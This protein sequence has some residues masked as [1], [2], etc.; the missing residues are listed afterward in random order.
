MTPDM[1]PMTPV[2]PTT[3]PQGPV[4][5][6]P[7]SEELLTLFKKEI[8]RARNHRDN[9]ISE[10]RVEDNLTRYLPAAATA[11]GV[12]VGVD[13]RDVERKGAALFYDTPTVNVQP[14]P[15]GNPQAAVLQQELING[16]LSAQRMNG[17]ATAIKAIKDCLVAIQPAFTVLGY[18]PVTVDVPSD[19]PGLPPTTQVAHDAFF[20]A[21]TSNKA[22]L[23][24]VDFHDTDYQQSPWIGYDW[25]KPCQQAIRE[26]NLP[27]DWEPP[28]G[29][30]RAVTFTEE[31]DKQPSS[32]PMCSGTLLWYRA[33]Q[34]DP[35]VRHPELLRTLVLIDG[36]DQ[37]VQHKIAPWQIGPNGQ[38]LLT[39]ATM[40]GYPIR[41][42]ALRDAPDH[43][44]VPADSS[45][46]GPLTKEINAYL[47]QAKTKRESNRLILLVDAE[48]ID[49][50]A[51]DK[52]K[53]L[54]LP[55]SMELAIVPV[56][57]GALDGGL[58][59]VMQQVQTLDLGRETY[60][61]L[62]IF[63]QK[64][65]QIL[66]I[67]APQGG[68]QNKKER[69]ATEIAT[70]QRNADARFEQERQRVLEWWLGVVRFLS[71]LLVRYGERWAVDILGAPRAQQWM[72]F[73]DQGLLG[74]FTFEVSIDS[75]KYLDV[76]ADRRQFLQV[77]NF[78][79]KSPFVNQQTM[80]RKFCEKF[81]YDPAEWLVQPQPPKPDPPGLTVSAK[82]EDFVM[83]QGVI[84]LEMMKA[85]GYPVDAAAIKT[86][87]GLKLLMPPVA[88]KPG[89]A[90]D[91]TSDGNAVTESTADK[92][93]RLDQHQLNETGGLS[94]PGQM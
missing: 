63:E 94:G 49:P 91:S 93:P 55:E 83:P 81:G 28:K 16:A 70:V 53:A 26:F 84:L 78:A 82:A 92:A 35:T 87:M 27:T 11:T 1:A 8:E 39:A 58:Q 37:P 54:R 15:D 62:E 86:A 4:L 38:P 33:S 22:G 7:I 89:D 57:Q 90:A 71:A 3:E 20:F 5:E 73:R 77:I 6:V 12:N 30:D 19:V 68:T 23:L 17:K 36:Y 64:R 72:Q 50:D 76:E 34:F 74:P 66:G 88:A 41:P 10:W 79:A 69:T 47:D 80:W 40:I 46:T 43:A 59:S 44:W 31:K 24:P 9:K 60:L 75:G 14:G 13:F 2:P 29:G 61:G 32:E 21:R 51:A 25:K 18:D 48:K 85:L 56:Q 67:S 52:I 65:D 42:L 45:Q